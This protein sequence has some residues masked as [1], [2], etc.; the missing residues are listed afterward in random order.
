MKIRKLMNILLTSGTVLLTCAAQSVAEE[1]VL[2]TSG[3]AFGEALKENFFDAFTE[4]TG[5]DI[6]VVPA[7]TVEGLSLLRAQVQSGNVQYDIITTT[8]QTIISDADLLQDIDCERVP[9]AAAY[10]VEG[11]CEGKKVIRNYGANMIA[12][13]TDRFPD[14]GPTTWSEFF[15]VESFP[16]RRCLPGGTIENEMPFLAA[17]L[18]DGVA[19]DELYPLDLD[20][21]MDVLRELRPNISA[22]YTSFSMSQQLLRD[23]ECD[24]SMM[25][26]GRALS[27]QAEG[28]PLAVSWN[29]AFVD[30]GNWSVPVGAP[31]EDAAYEFLNFWMTRPEA[32]LAFY[33][34]FYYGTA[35]AGVTELMSEE[36]LQS[37]HATEANFSQ[38]IPLNVEWLAANEDEISRRYASFLTE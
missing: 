20:R 18:A 25:A 38:L 13:V 34:T 21:A 30:T 15:D 7:S 22:Y 3:G 37:Y 36:D 19:E 4:E 2:V 1:I 10:G 35:H 29:Q 24:M 28:F 9:N 32:H 12:Y 5:I 17:L 16:G 23:G 33:R 8:N 31:N 11:T 27:L 6:I 14:G 26:S